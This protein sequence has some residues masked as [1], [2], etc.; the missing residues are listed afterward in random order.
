[1]SADASAVERL[2]CF[3]EDQRGV[4]QSED[5]KLLTRHD[6]LEEL[7]GRGDDASV[8]ETDPHALL[9]AQQGF[10]RACAYER[11]SG[12]SEACPDSPLD[13]GSP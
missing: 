7:I 6:N 9:S 3:V 11:T 12:G 8:A 10:S 5:L 13:P 4:E 2:G 1:M